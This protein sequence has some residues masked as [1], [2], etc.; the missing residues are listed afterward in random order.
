MDGLRDMVGNAGLQAMKQQHPANL[1]QGTDDSTIADRFMALKHAISNLTFNQLKGAP[2]RKTK[3]KLHVDFFTRLNG[4]AGEQNYNH[5][6]AAP[7]KNG[8]RRRKELI[9]QAVIWEILNE[10]LLLNPTTVFYNLQDME[11]IKFRAQSK[12]RMFCTA[13]SITHS[14]G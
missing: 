10:R 1:I 3:K 13:S 5:Y 4:D 11:T 8:P 2:F 7:N 9:F 12:M 6:L 14:S